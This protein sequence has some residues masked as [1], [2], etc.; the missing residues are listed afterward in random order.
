MSR[1]VNGNRYDFVDI[2]LM[3]PGGVLSGVKS[4]SYSHEAPIEDTHDNKGK[5]DG[6]IRKNYKASG[7]MELPRAEA[8]RLRGALGGGYMRTPFSIVCAYA[9]DGGS[10]TVDTL[11]EVVITKEDTGGSQEN[12]VT[13]KFDF[14]IKELLPG[15]VSAIQ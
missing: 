9:N 11:N 6:A 12:E 10:V 2:Q 15:G 14:R 7:S 4:I 1:T 5:V 3:T 8:D 13:S